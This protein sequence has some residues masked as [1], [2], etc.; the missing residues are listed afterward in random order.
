MKPF[1]LKFCEIHDPWERGLGCRFGPIKPYSENVLNLKF[2]FFTPTHVG[3][4]SK[5][6]C[7]IRMYI[8]MIL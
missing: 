4:T 5:D 1:T 6:D 7:N 2:I 8:T 3:K